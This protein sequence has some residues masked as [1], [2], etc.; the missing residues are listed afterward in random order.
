MIESLWRYGYSYL[1]FV[2]PLIPCAYQMFSIIVD[3]VYVAAAVHL[4]IL[5]NNMLRIDVSSKKWST[6]QIRLTDYDYESLL[7][8]LGTLL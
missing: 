1:F 2:F 3:V 5:Q 4:K 8:Y 7:R 6:C